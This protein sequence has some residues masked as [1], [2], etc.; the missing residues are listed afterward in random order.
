MKLFIVPDL[1]RVRR[2][3]YRANNNTD[4]MTKPIRNTTGGITQMNVEASG[5]D[6]SLLGE[7]CRRV[8]KLIRM[9]RGQ[10]W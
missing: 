3:A 1:H 10:S 6:I 9:R 2:H 8:D 4:M 7:S 5:I